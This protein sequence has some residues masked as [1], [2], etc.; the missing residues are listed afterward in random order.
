MYIFINHIITGPNIIEGFSSCKLITSLSTSTLEGW[1]YLETWFLYH[2]F[3]ESSDKGIDILN[4]SSSLS[5][6]NVVKIGLSTRL[7][8]SLKED[9]NQQHVLNHKTI[10]SQVVSSGVVSSGLKNT[11]K[12]S[13]INTMKFY[14]NTLNQYN[15]VLQ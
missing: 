11:Q 4:L 14:N 13:I 1:I 3:L 8:C 10:A 6:F 7:H 5:T 2:G 9:L 12:Y 15:E